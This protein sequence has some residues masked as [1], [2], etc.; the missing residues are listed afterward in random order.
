M[1]Q[2]SDRG[3]SSKIYNDLQNSG[4]KKL[5]VI[6]LKWAQR[7]GSLETLSPGLEVLKIPTI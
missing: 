4:I 5:T 3:L 1:P 6:F 7:A 2:T